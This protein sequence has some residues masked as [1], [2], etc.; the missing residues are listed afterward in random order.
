LYSSG[1]RK[2]SSKKLVFAVIPSISVAYVT[3]VA[4]DTPVRIETLDWFSFVSSLLIY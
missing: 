1:S 2:S 4:Y 3:A